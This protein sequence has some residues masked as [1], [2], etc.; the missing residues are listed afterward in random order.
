MNKRL[1]F[2]IKI[3]LFLP[4]IV[5]WV[6]L[7][8]VWIMLILHRVWNNRPNSPQTENVEPVMM[9]DVYREENEVYTSSEN[10]M[11]LFNAEINHENTTFEG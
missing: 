11:E 10:E 2:G 8:C 5:I 3:A 4:V 1:S 7:I 9:E 6:I